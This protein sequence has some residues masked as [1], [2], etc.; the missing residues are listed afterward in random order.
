MALMVGTVVAFITPVVQCAHA[1]EPAADAQDKSDFILTPP[2]PATPRI[3]G[4]RIYGQRPGRPFLFTVPATGDRPLKFAA[5][6]LPHGLSIDEMTGR[7]TGSVK[8]V[9]EFVV[10]LR[11][12]NDKGT[13]TKP[14]KIVIGDQI[15]LTPPM[16]WIVPCWLTDPVT[17]MSWRIGTSANAESSA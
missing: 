16:G 10:T 7:I 12:T 9:G 3:N 14:L 4:A 6:G 11:A 15:A 1:Q 2:P 17:A 5:D 8:D 13:D